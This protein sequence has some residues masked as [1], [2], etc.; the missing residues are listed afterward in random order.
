MRVSVMRVCTFAS[1]LVVLA[2]S[3][4]G[5]AQAQPS[6]VPAPEIDTSAIPAAVGLLSAGVLML[7]ARRSK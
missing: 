5:V 2:L 6:T 3:V 7:R 4:A 1:A